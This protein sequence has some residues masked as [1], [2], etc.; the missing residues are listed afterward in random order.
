[1]GTKVKVRMLNSGTIRIIEK[2]KYEMEKELWHLLA[3][4]RDEVED[5]SYQELKEMLDE[6]GISYK[7]NASKATLR[8][9]LK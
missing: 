2:D 1:M 8:G 6:A 4:E 5:L 7:R 3:E 9:L